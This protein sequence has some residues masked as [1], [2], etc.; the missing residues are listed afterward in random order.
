MASFLLEVGT[1]ELPARFVDEALAQWRSRIPKELKELNLAT[2]AIEFYGTPRRLAVLIKGLPTQQADVEEEVK[3][4][5]VKA[6]FKDDQ[7]TKAATGF[8]QKQGVKVEDFEIRPTP[9]GEFIFVK[10]LI[11]GRPVADLLT[12]MVPSLITG[13]DGKRLMRWGNGDVRFSRPVRWLVALLDAAV[14]PL[15]FTNGAE[16]VYTS[17]RLSAGHRVLHPEPVSIAQADDYVATLRKACV[18]VDLEARRKTIVEQAEAAAKKVGGVATI[19]PGLLQE[20]VNLV[21][22]PS[23]V[24]GSFDEEF[25]ALP[26]EVVVT[27]M[28]SHQRYFP[29]R[30]KA[31]SPDL[32][33]YFITT[34]NGDPKKA[35]IIASGNQRVIRA[36]LSDGK[37][38][39]DADQKLK[40]EGFLPKLDTVTFQADLGS[41]SAKVKRLSAIA[42]QIS[43]QLGINGADRQHIDRA[44]QLCKA[45]LVTQMVGEF[46][47]LQGV[48]GEKYAR[49]NGEPEA[50]AL[51]IMEHY[52]PKGAGDCL[53][54]SFT[55]QVVGIADRLDTLVGIFSLG[56]LPT[57]SS[58]PF[59]LRRAANAVV[60]VI[61]DADLQLD[62]LK[63]LEDVVSGFAAQHSDVMKLKPD[64]L[65][66]QLKDFFLARVQTALKDDKSIDYDLINSVVGENDA[67]YADRALRDL[68]SVRDRAEFLQTI[69]N[70]GRLEPIYAVVNR[71]SKLA[72][73]GDLD[74]QARD[75]K[76]CVK[77]DLFQK[78]SEKALFDAVV[79]L[80]SDGDMDDLVAAL[81]AIAPALTNFFDGDDSVLVMDPDA[82]I[83]QNRL[84][85]LG[86]LRN[87]ARVLADFSAIVK[88]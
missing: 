19:E 29:V 8:A 3:G 87:H 9:K 42:T 38:F 58:D 32:L 14:L 78:N 61:W 65:L 48:M 88:S 69:R 40:L 56:M 12:E 64:E 16:A 26:S 86:V 70:D 75:V 66:Q 43:D 7:P 25:L 5:P 55:G 79:N 54:Q 74:T 37:F 84:N 71:A 45:D 51:A 85:L 1:E 80:K 83:K 36:R 81:S 18:E 6:A 50:V 82:N 15:T 53:P 17:D 13:L 60:S 46:P 47:E 11:K 77:P 76:A 44:A 59:A 24:V 21:E 23:A 67:E 10:K 73:K 31:D 68:L 22:Y 39:F 27:E 20:V 30:P 62:L 28:E 63:L 49:Q 41:M 35:D 52:L 72:T 33:P 4:P 2:S 34:S 57:G